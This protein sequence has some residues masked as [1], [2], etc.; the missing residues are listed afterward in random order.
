MKK[1]SKWLLILMLIC[2]NTVSAVDGVIEINQTCAVH[3]G[4][5]ENNSAGFP[6]LISG[7]AKTSY[8]LT[9]DLVLPDENTTAIMINRINVSIDLNGYSIMRTGCHTACDS[10]SGTGSGIE[11]LTNGFSGVAIKNGTISG[12]GRDGVRS[13]NGSHITVESLRVSS[14]GSLGIRLDIASIVRGCTVYNNNQGIAGDDYSIINNNT[15]YSNEQQGILVHNSLVKSNTVTGNGSYGISS[16]ESSKIHE[17]I[18]LQNAGD[19]IQLRDFS[20]TSSR[21]ALINDN[22]ISGNDLYGI[23]VISGN[24]H[25]FSGNMITN[26]F[27][28]TISGTLFNMGNNFCTSNDV[29]P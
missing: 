19:G 6:V 7:D 21:G 26:N 16:Y 29:C 20:P 4:C 25:V 1:I 12:L 2:I 22:Q 13:L 10:I 9:S 3:T 15:V 11:I 14:N 28:G 8:R 24:R 17:N 27:S 5:H 23:K 18:I